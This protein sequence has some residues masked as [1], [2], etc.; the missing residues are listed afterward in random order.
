LLAD[1]SEYISFDTTISNTLY[2]PLIYNG[3]GVELW[4]ELW[5]ELWQA[6]WIE[7]YNYWNYDATCKVQVI[8]SLTA[9]R[10]SNNRNNRA[11]GVTGDTTDFIVDNT[12]K[13]LSI[14]DVWVD[15]QARRITWSVWILLA[16]WMNT[17]RLI[18]NNDTTGKQIKVYYNNTYM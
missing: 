2:D 18:A 10:I 6:S 3:W 9:P 1:V 15:I 17:I 5:N 7:I 12:G 14:T 8:W 11:Y 13:K 16:P 4:V